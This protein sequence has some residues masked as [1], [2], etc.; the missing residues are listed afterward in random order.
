MAFQ[1]TD[2]LLSPDKAAQ[3]TKALSNLGVA[4]P[5]QYLCD[6]AAADVARLT[7]GYVT[8]DG[9]L[10]NFTRK[11]ALFEIYSK[12]Q[13]GAVPDGIVKDH[14][15]ALKELQDIAAGKRPNLPKV[16]TPSQATIAGA[17][18]SGARVCGRIPGQS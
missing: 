14:D 3:L 9:S 12:A 7:T 17:W 15:E 11:L 6:E 1:T 18:G 10:R 13:A 2:L 16:S 4:D 5:L 8:D